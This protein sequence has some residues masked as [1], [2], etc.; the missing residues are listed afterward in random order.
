MRTGIA[1]DAARPGHEVIVVSKP[2]IPLCALLLFGAAQ[3]STPAPQDLEEKVTLL[4]KRLAEA[5][6]ARAEQGRRLA[7]LEESQA[8]TQAWFQSLGPAL[9]ALH[10]K[11]DEARKNGFEKAGPNP[12]A[13]KAVLDGIQSFSKSLSPKASAPETAAT[14]RRR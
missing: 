11:M 3:V 7:A 6:E 12:R 9:N 13:K 1:P 14:R 10:G 4:E 8:R 5:D 2:L